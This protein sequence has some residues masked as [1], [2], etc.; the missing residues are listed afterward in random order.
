MA[1][2]WQSRVQ[3]HRQDWGRATFLKKP[4]VVEKHALSGAREPPG[5]RSSC[6]SRFCSKF[7]GILQV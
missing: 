5:D 7:T 3:H 4:L 1:M 2:W 6:E